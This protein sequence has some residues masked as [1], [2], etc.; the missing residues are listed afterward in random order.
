VKLR[1][2]IIVPLFLAACGQDVR[3]LRL[4]EV[5][6][7][8]MAEVQRLGQSLTPA[9]RPAFATFVAIHG[10]AAAGNCGL[11]LGGREGRTPETIGEAIEAMQTRL[12]AL[13]QPPAVADV[14]PRPAITPT[15]AYTGPS[16]AEVNRQLEILE[17]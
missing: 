14:A 1:I 8:D 7:S 13:Q 12:A 4:D 2:A 16:L 11:T 10:R 3:G 17:R 6:L 9:E 5:D 15:A